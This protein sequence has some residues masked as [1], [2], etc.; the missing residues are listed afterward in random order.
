M[1]NE[2]PIKAID[3][4]PNNAINAANPG[5]SRLPTI[6]VGLAT[7]SVIA[8]PAAV[9]QTV[10]AAVL[11]AAPIAQQAAPITQAALTPTSSQDQPG[12]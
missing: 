5:Y 11:Q 4:T 3:T 1:A 9:L 10:P 6:P 2:T 7:P 12:K 8:A